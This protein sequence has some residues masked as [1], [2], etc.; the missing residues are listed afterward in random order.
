MK[1]VILTF[2]FV[3]VAQLGFAQDAFKTD[4][5]KYMDMSGQMAIFESLTSEWENNVTDDKKADFRKELTASLSLLKDKMAEM[6]MTEF[7]HN[8]IKELIKF[9][10]SPIG[11]K[12]S[13]KNEVLMEKGEQVGQEWAVGLQGI[14]MKY[15]Q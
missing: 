3:L 5:K 14:M 9:Y 6:Y 1:K 10:E 2:V 13:S 11:K 4:T 7:T 8:D 12:L 15:M